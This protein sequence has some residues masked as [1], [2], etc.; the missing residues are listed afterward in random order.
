MKELQ[1]FNRRYNR[2]ENWYRAQFRHAGDAVAIGEAT[3]GYMYFEEA[4]PRMRNLVP[5][6][7]LIAILRDPVDRA[8]SDYWYRLAL[9]ESRSFA[10]VVRQEIADGVPFH[11]TMRI[12]YLETGRYVRY[13]RRVCEHYPRESLLVLLT[14]DLR[15]DPEGTFAGLCRF[16]DIDDTFRPRSLGRASNEAYSL[17]SATVRRT[18]WWL[19]LGQ[20]SMWLA[21]RLDKLNRSR[22]EYPPMD[23]EI[24]AELKAWYATDNAELGEWLGRDLSAWSS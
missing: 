11:K 1:F 9:G 7:R 5:D 13:L 19:R 18:M 16:I 24:R 12:G 23:P 10:E 3:P 21:K 8:Y 2:G 14:D 20:R 6:A 17:R 15:S 22:L 4:L